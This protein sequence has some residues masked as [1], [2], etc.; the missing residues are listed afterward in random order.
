MKQ[1]KKKHSSLENEVIVA[2]TVL[3]LLMM[4]V[5]LVIHYA[6]PAGQVT[7]SSSLSHDKPDT[8]A[9]AGDSSGNDEADH[10]RKK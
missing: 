7:V 9:G 10:V 2:V 1:E 6:Q 8:V 3:Y 5:F 4:G